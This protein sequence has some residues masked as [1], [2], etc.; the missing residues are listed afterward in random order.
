[1]VAAGTIAVGVAACGSG[2]DSTTTSSTTRADAHAGGGGGGGGGGQKP[3]SPGPGAPPKTR[4]THPRAHPR[5][6]G[7]PGSTMHHTYP[8]RIISH[9]QAQGG[10][11]QPAELWPVGNGWR[12]SDHRTFTAVYAGASPDKHSIGRLVIFRQNYVRVT[13]TSDRV[14]V[15]G[16][17]RLE[18][19][20]APS[21]KK[22]G[23]SAQ[24]TGEIEFRGTNGVTGTLHLADDS[25]TLNSA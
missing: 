7:P 8:A 3:N 16:A 2:T 1:M 10:P 15:P 25:V 18:I 19:T 21:G 6:Q 13:Q 24:Q 20:G 5:R 17:G 9:S 12:V 11:V 14:D 4:T 23:T 22:V